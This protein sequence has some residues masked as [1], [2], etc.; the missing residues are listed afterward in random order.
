MTHAGVTSTQQK[1]AAFVDSKSFAHAL[2]HRFVEENFSLDHIRRQYEDL[3]WALLEEK[4]GRKTSFH[5]R[6]TQS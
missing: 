2:S 6:G 5:E 3:Y 4:R 1:P